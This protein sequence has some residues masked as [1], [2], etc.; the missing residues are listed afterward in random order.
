MLTEHTYYD[1][2]QL[3]AT[4]Q[5]LAQRWPA[6]TRLS[7]LGTTDGG[8]E[9]WLLTLGRRPDAKLPALCVDANMH[10]GE[11]VGTTL[12][13]NFAEAV[14]GFLEN[15]VMPVG[16]PDGLQQYLSDG[17]IHLIPRSSPDGAEAV[18]KAHGYVRSIPH[19]ED[20]REA[21]HWRLQDLD[22]DGFIKTM[23]KE[24]PAGRWSEL[25]G[26][27]ASVLVPRRIEDSGPFYECYYEGLIQNPDGR[28]IPSQFID[29]FGLDLN[30]NYPSGWEGRGKQLG[31]G[32]LPLAVPESRI[33]AKFVLSHPN[34]C[35]WINLHTFGGV[36]LTPP[37][38]EP[39]DQLG[40]D[41]KAVWNLVRELSELH[42]EYPT[43][44]ISAEFAYD[45]VAR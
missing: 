30:R 36:V 42:L 34:I 40:P 39:A 14:L 9:I 22:G 3:S 19:P 5:R 10:A 17:L 15:G 45:P 7:S 13:L 35:F 25:P 27:E 29:A 18:L 24:T 8:R 26:S 44:A 4:L 31:G 12:I 37:I 38:H 23:R 28:T 1:Y 41:E 16:V 33:L 20:A 6:F 2:E 11:L 43:H 32:D 21:P